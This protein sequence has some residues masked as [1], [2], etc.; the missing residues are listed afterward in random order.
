MGIVMDDVSSFF[1]YNPKH[2]DF[3]VYYVQMESVIT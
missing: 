1:K 3:F 2:K